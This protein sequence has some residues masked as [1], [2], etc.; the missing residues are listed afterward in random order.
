MI[1]VNPPAV[2]PDEADD[3][4]EKYATP[5]QWTWY[6]KWVE[7][8]SYS[9]AAR[10]VGADGTTLRRGIRSIYKKAAQQGYAPHHG[11]VHEVPEGMTS[12]GTSVL[13]DGDGEVQ[14]Y[15]NKTT[16]QGKEPDEAIQ[17]P[18]G[19]AV[20]VSTL[21]DNA[22]RVQQQWVQERP[23]DRD[24]IE[25]W[26]EIAKELAKK[27]EPLPQIS[28]PGQHMDSDL[29]VGY[30]VSD[31]HLGMLS[32]DRETGDDWD[33]KIGEEML[34]K[35]IAYLVS[36]APKSDEALIAFMGD[37]MHYDS[38]DTVT[39][40]QRNLLDADGRYPKMVRAAIRAMRNTIEEVAK[41]HRVVRVIIEIGN[42]DLSSSI[43]LAEAMHAL[44]E[45][46]PRIFIDTSPMHFHYAE[47]GKVL[48]GTHHGHGVKMDK[49]PGLMASDQH[50]AW[51]RTEHR[52]WWTGHIHHTQIHEFPG[53]NVESFRV[54]AP[55][56]AWHH[57]RGYRAARDL[58]AIVFHKDYGEVSRL[59]VNPEMFR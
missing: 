35:S 38:F 55:K 6:L 49:L 39:P 52:V 33:I 25:I 18:D 58:K 15:W 54:L 14:G 34:N 50:E 29:F 20:K 2:A 59:T 57:Q 42:H 24:R 26:T 32:W 12:K 21:Y 23:E 30:P 48:I 8:G 4:L 27:I 53:C 43:F 36:A 37:F 28:S 56:D 7:H 51:G 40:T 22:G 46:T 31:L 11:L 45:N 19:V 44:Y 16:R 41:K 10:D 3:R 47:Y 13:Y 17:L 9:A 5:L 1:E